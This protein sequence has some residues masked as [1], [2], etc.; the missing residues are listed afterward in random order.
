VLAHDATAVLGSIKAPTLVTFGR[1][2]MVTSTRFAAPLTEAIGK[3]EVIVFEDCAHTPIYENA[4]GFNEQT[5]AFLQR[6]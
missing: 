1:Y 4:N 3:S 6:H 5:L 2:D